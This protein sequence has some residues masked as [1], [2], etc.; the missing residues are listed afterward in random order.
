MEP[1][2]IGEPRVLLEDG[3]TAHLSCAK[4]DDPRRL[5]ERADATQARREERQR[6]AL[7]GWDRTTFP[8]QELV[9]PPPDFE[10]DG[11]E[12]LFDHE[13]MDR[14]A[15]W[16]SR[17]VGTDQYDLHDED[18]QR[19]ATLPPEIAEQAAATV[20]QRLGNKL[21][22]DAQALLDRAQ[23]LNDVPVRHMYESPWWSDE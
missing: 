4:A 14:V 8:P 16:V 7:D 1:P 3:G 11:R 19:I 9:Y 18:E 2:P 23:A 15:L 20:R 5:A 21:T 22:A 6:K 17:P 13:D 12:Y 10:H